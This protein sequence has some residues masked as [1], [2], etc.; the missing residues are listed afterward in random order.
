M[1][2]QYV[3][4]CDIVHV[5]CRPLVIFEMSC[6]SMNRNYW[7]EFLIHHRLLEVFIISKLL[8]TNIP[9]VNLTLLSLVEVRIMMGPHD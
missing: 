5:F 2:L 9:L 3:M 8:E 4:F 6:M 7:I 1:N